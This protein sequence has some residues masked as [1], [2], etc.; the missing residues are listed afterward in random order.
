MVIMTNII[1]YDEER[2][3][4]CLLKMVDLGESTKSR[5]NLALIRAKWNVF[6]LNAVFAIS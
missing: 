4:S 1:G 6:A 2:K 3:F 5:M